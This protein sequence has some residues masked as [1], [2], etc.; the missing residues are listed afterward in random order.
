MMRLAIEQDQHAWDAFVKQANDG[1]FLQSWQWGELQKKLSIPFWRIIFEHNGQ[2]NAV[3]LVI[4]RNISFGKSWLYVPKGPLLDNE[5][6]ELWQ[7][8]ENALHE[9]AQKEKALFI[10]IDPEWTDKKHSLAKWKKSAREVQPQHTLLLDLKKSEEEL[11]AAMHHK[12]R[13]NIRLAQKKGVTVRFSSEAV[14]LKHFLRLTQDVNER[15]SFKF[16]PAKY[17]RA[18]LETLGTAGHME[19]ALAE[20]AHEVLAAHLII[21]FNTTSTYAHGA[22]SSKARSVMAPHLLQWET[23][24]RAKQKG[25]QGY[26]FYGVSAPDAPENHSW[27]GIT[28]FKEGFGGQRRAYIGAHD[29]VLEP[30][31]YWAYNTMHRLRK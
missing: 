16:H 2:W 26:D 7:E 12:T 22:S 21:N 24:Q 28:R 19:I 1:S 14:D 11:L 23:I 17:Y 25:V 5:S 27:H 29:L 18:L 15:S 8:V 31:W 13:Y 9:L 30:F 3:A 10:R 4:K 6:P 20:Y